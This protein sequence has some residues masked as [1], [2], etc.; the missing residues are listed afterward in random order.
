M[1]NKNGSPP[2]AY[3]KPEKIS[4]QLKGRPPEHRP[5]T[6]SINDRILQVGMPGVCRGPPPGTIFFADARLLTRGEAAAGADRGFLDAG[7]F[8]KKTLPFGHRRRGG[9]RPRPILREPPNPR[10]QKIGAFAE[11]STVSRPDAQAR[12]PPCRG[13]RRADRARTPCLRGSSNIDGDHEVVMVRG[14][15]IVGHA[16]CRVFRRRV[17]E[18]RRGGEGYFF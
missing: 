9:R 15:E 17:R 8:Q 4:G 14:E 2:A 18:R 6:T 7:F 3:A 1:P 10:R 5:G 11:E 16:G 12:P 13:G